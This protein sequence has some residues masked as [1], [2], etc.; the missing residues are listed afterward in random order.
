MSESSVISDER[1]KRIQSDPRF[2]RPKKDDSKI[3]I[4]KRFAGMLKSN[5]SKTKKP[6]V[7]KRGKTIKKNAPL[8]DMK[9]FYKQDD[10]LEEDEKEKEN[11]DSSDEKKI[12]ENVESVELH[13]ASSDSESEEA[14]SDI[15][16]SDKISGFD[17]ARGHGQVES[18]EEES[19]E[20]ETVVGQTSQNEEEEENIPLG[21]ETNRIAAV[22]L[23]WDHIKAQ[24]IF[25][26]FHSFLQ[27]KNSATGK[28]V[29][30]KIY[31]SEFGKA[32]LKE[33]EMGPPKEIF[34]DTNKLLVD[35]DGADFDEAKLRKY[36]LDRLKYYYS[37]TE[38]D[39]V[40][41][42]KEIY[43][44]CDGTEFESSGNFLDLRF[45]PDGT[46]FLEADVIDSCYKEEK[47]YVQKDFQTKALQHTKVSLTWDQDDFD[48]VKVTK[49]KFTKEDLKDMDFKSYVASSESEEEDEEGLREKYR[50]LFMG[51]NAEEEESDKEK[52]EDMEITFT[53]GLS[54]KVGKA[55][56]L[57]KDKIFEDETVFQR[58]LRLQKEKKKARKNQ[59]KLA[60]KEVDSDDALISNEDDP[61]GGFDD[62]FFANSSDDDLKQNSKS[63][64]EKNKKTKESAA[65]RIEKKKN[66]EKLNLLMSNENSE[67]TNMNHYEM[68][69]ILKMEKLKNLSSKKK[70][71]KK[72]VEKKINMIKQ[73]ENIQDDFKLNLKDERFKKLLEDSEFHIDPT[74]AKFKKTENMKLLRNEIQKNKLKNM[75]HDTNFSTVEKIENEVSPSVG[76]NLKSLVDSVK[77]K[78]EAAFSNEKS[79]K[80]FKK[81]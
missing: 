2:K 64:K 77:R 57:K 28:I 25:K 68:K 69:D 75:E 51:D 50:S 53:P 44:I 72:K 23:D 12:V 24:D 54:E 60:E 3:K 41:T 61:E 80:R 76:S 67:N 78:S 55:A 40:N 29:S 81:K 19:D 49:R 21:D 63:K 73:E 37:V 47:N 42:A 4:D 38:F 27:T 16:K 46:E 15:Q 26:L 43:N 17:L 39:S 56:L 58:N 33:E 20:E 35:D 10:E 14:L 65:E 79:G 13:S 30:V 11:N 31:V 66:L 5:F 74:N 8:E 22:N 1:F 32:K 6:L 62:E 9:R 7:D 48:R 52:M 36:Q 34:E 45:I 70:S 18:S 71:I 59:R